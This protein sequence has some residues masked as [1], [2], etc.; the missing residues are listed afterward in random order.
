MLKKNILRKNHQFQKVI[1][2]K[3]QV[4]TKAIVLYHL[5]N[6][7]GL[8]IGISISKKFANAVKRNK[9]RRQ[10]RHIFDKLNLWDQYSKDIV[11]IVRKPFL[12]MDNIKKVEAIKT[13]FE[14][15]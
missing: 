5:N 15:L 14:R 13:I 9:Y 2:K 4:V 3:Q 8:R 10:I 7:F 12:E 11:L 1:S 6:N